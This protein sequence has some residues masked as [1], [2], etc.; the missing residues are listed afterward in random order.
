MI[1]NIMNKV[2][3]LLLMSTV[4]VIIEPN[5]K[6]RQIER[7]K[8]E[9]RHSCKPNHC[10]NGNKRDIAQRKTARGSVFAQRIPLNRY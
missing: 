10:W 9:G 3:M 1:Y 5:S 8:G 7:E 4:L 2:I 6:T